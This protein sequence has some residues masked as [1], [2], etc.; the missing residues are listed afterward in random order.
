MHAVRARVVVM[1]GAA[2]AMAFSFLV[3]M[4][5]GVW[6]LA[7]ASLFVGC[8]TLY[9]SCCIALP[10]D[11]FPASSLGSVHG[12]VGTSS[13]LGGVISTGLV[14]TVITHWSYDTVFIGMSFLHPLATLMLVTLLPRAMKLRD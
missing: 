7:W 6:V 14:A 10:I 2:I 3:P 9:M 12:L 4:G 8:T 11:L 13:S 5:G 1:S